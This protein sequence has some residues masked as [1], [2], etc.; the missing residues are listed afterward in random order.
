MTTGKLILAGTDIGNRVD[1]PARSLD[2]LRTGSLLVFE[3]SRNARAFLKNG[4]HPSRFFVCYSEHEEKALKAVEEALRENK[5]V[6]YMSDQGMPNVADPGRA[7]L[8]TACRL[9]AQVEIIPG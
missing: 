1:I 7:L 6:V 5:T 4:W 9:R 2:A 8:K 3:G